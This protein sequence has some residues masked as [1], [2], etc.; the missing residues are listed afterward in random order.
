MQQLTFKLIPDCFRL[1]VHKSEKFP[2]CKPNSE[3]GLNWTS[4]FN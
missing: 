3:K 2:F 4:S 1:E